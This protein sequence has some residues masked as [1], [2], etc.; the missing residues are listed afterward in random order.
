MKPDM[1]GRLA[2]DLII[3]VEEREKDIDKSCPFLKNHLSM[4]Y[5]L[6]L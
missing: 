3:F 6:H 1:L 4:L 5:Q 2:D